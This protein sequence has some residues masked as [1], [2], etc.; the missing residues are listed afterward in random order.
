M[1][2]VAGLADVPPPPFS[3]AYAASP[4]PPG[5]LPPEQ[6]A[7]AAVPVEVS[8][9]EPPAP[10]DVGLGIGSDAASAAEMPPDPEIACR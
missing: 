2:G 3:E 9:A 1:S 5:D 4:A 7:V 6:G 10:E 8:A